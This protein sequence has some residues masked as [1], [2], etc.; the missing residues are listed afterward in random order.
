M[1]IWANYPAHMGGEQVKNPDQQQQVS[2]LQSGGKLDY[3]LD[4]D[5][6]GGL[7]LV[8]VDREIGRSGWGVWGMSFWG[9]WNRYHATK[10]AADAVR[11]AQELVQ[12]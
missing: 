7:R 1:Q 6:H 2:C 4:A 9:D 8:K 10:D 11:K 5:E 3:A 12:Q